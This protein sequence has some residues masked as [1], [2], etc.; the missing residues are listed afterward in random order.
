VGLGLAARRALTK[1][2]EPVKIEG[3]Q[4]V[5]AVP[6]GGSIDES[7][8]VVMTSKKAP[9]TPVVVTELYDLGAE[10]SQ[11]C[12]AVWP[13]QL[14]TDRRRV[15]RV[16]HVSACLDCD[17]MGFRQERPPGSQKTRKKLGAAQ[18][19]GAFSEFRGSIFLVPVSRT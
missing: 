11:I 1:K 8:H 12:V 4:P 10:E 13:R 9:G 18:T 19:H 15:P 6:V 7:V 16:H 2:A 14:L 17:V 3:T 5:G